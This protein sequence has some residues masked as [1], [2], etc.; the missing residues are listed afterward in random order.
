[1]TGLIDL[2][3][4]E[5]LGVIGLKPKTV[6]NY[7]SCM[8]GFF[9]FIHEISVELTF[10]NEKHL[11]MFMVRLKNKGLSFSRLNHHRSS[12]QSFFTFLVKIKA[13]PRNPAESMFPIK[14]KRSELN[15]PVKPESVH[16]LLDSY[17]LNNF[18]GIRNFTMVSIFWALGIRNNELRTLKVGSFDPAFDRNNRIGLLTVDGKNNKERSLFVVDKLYDNL[19]L[20]LSHRKA[21]KNKKFPLFCTKKNQPISGDQVNRIIRNNVKKNRIKER[22]TPHVLRHTFATEMYHIGVPIDDIR[23]MLGHSNIAE[24]SLYIHVSDEYLKTALDHLSLSGSLS[25]E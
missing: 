15:K 25:W 14:S 3:K 20:Y 16:A 10:V 5:L 7:I 18:R 23:V 19:L 21:P 9:S 8:T 4:K 22:I 13:V 17:D 2:Y 6:Q 24:T 1:M 11:L 12:L